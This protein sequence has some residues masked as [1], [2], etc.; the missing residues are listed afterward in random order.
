MRSFLPFS[1]ANHQSAPA[2]APRKADMIF[3]LAGRKCRK[4]YGLHLFSQGLSPRILVSV[5]R[6]ELRRFPE[7]ELPVQVDLL[8]LAAA[9]PPPRRHYFVEFCGK[10]VETTLIR[11]RRF[12]TLAEIEAL[13]EQ[14]SQRTDTVSVL[15][16]S[17]H[18]HL[19][20][21]RL[22][23]RA[24]L[25]KHIEVFFA[26]V[27]EEVSGDSSRG[28]VQWWRGLRDSILEMVKL[29]VYRFVLKFRTLW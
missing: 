25:A 11:T 24:L 26:A 5:G 8:A 29:V 22:C 21:I 10:Q 12:G 20:R 1:A 15:V 9:V 23:C 14:L 13:A 3:V 7:L 4:V 6:F 2:D 18:R 16:I 17:S 19:R 27:P 28:L